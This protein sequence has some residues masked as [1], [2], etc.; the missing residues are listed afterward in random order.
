MFNELPVPDHVIKEEGDD[1]G[2]L[3]VLE[4][5]LCLMRVNKGFHAYYPSTRIMEKL[6]VPYGWC[7]L[8]C[9]VSLD[10][11]SGYY[12]DEAYDYKIAS[13]TAIEALYGND[14]FYEE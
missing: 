7:M 10:S 6:E 3:G 1:L 2:H 8:P 11:L 14:D 4:E 5:L 13:T 12:W 9:V